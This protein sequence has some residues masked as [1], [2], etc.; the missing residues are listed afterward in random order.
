MKK[1]LYLIIP[2]FS[3]LSV[4]GQ[5]A[6]HIQKK[7]NRNRESFHSLSG[8][9]RKDINNHPIN[10]FIAKA[11]Q[12]KSAST[13][14][15]SLD[16]IYWQDW[17]TIS[18]NWENSIS[19]Y[20]TY[21]TNGD[22][23]ENID[24]EWDSHSNKW[25]IFYRDTYSYDANGNMTEELHYGKLTWED[26]WN[27][28][29]KYEYKYDANRKITEDIEYDWNENKTIWELRGK[30]IY[31]YNDNGN[32]TEYIYY[33]WNTILKEWD[34]DYK[35][36]YSYNA[37]GNMTEETYSEWNMNQTIWMNN[38][39]YTYSYDAYGDL[40]ESFDYDG[41]FNSS[42]WELVSKWVYTFDNSTASNDL[43]LPFGWDAFNFGHKMIQ[44]FE[45]KQSDNGWI[46]SG[47]WTN[48]YSPFN[49]TDI[50]EKTKI[51]SPVIFPNPA[52]D[53]VTFNIED[54]SNQ[55][56]ICIYDLNGREVLSQTVGNNVPVS[57]KELS[58]G[59]YIYRII[60]NTHA[61]TGKFF[62]E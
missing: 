52:S 35:G 9:G 55:S 36:E 13:I 54:G 42:I 12:F 34:K 17:D 39:K 16:S 58:K 15:Q 14:K 2:L 18:N 11:D 4:I 5:P 53:F 29:E 21:N 43:I 38:N 50:S 61:Y 1:Y 24:L 19:D 28:E 31:T 3:A 10:Q 23:T 47:K 37:N 22:N 25:Y 26:D 20:Y 40:T 41:A 8:V 57:V 32:N 30:S 44:A 51:N 49:V 46:L 27:L 7:M 56:S 6:D 48:Y 45:Y 59:L 60:D 62:K 33:S